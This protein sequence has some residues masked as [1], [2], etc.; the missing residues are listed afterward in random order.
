MTLLDDMDSETREGVRLLTTTAVDGRD[1]ASLDVVDAFV[2]EQ[3]HA[4]AGMLD[5][6]TGEA[7]IR[8]VGSLQVLDQVSKRV[9]GLRTVMSCGDVAN[10]VTDA[11][12]PVPGVCVAPGPSSETAGKAPGN[13]L[14][15]PRGGTPE[16]GSTV[17]PATPASNPGNAGTATPSPNGTP[18][19]AVESDATVVD[20]ILRMLGGG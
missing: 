11:L 20:R 19:D 16:S 12:G 10:L 15:N 13:G 3:H 9:H 18:M 6:V 7:R 14:K 1:P 8:T 4:I 17:S 2:A 5:T